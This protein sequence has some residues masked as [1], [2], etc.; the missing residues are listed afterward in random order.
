MYTSGH[1]GFAV[2]F[3]GAVIKGEGGYT[4]IE[5]ALAAVIISVLAVLALKGF[6]R[7]WL[8]WKEREQIVHAVAVLNALDNWWNEYRTVPTQT[9]LV[10]KRFIGQGFDFSRI[11]WT[12]HVNGRLGDAGVQPATCLYAPVYLEVRVRVPNSKGE[13]VGPGL[14]YNATTSE[15]VLTRSESQPVHSDYFAK[16]AL[17]GCTFRSQWG[18]P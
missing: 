11:T 9:D 12:V 8:Y 10:N 1:R 14:S 18:D 7:Q 3:H 4:L 5:L 17:D 2:Q 13:F 6:D 16:S 15:Y